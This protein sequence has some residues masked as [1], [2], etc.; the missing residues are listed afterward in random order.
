MIFQIFN[1]KNLSKRGAISSSPFR[2]ATVFQTSLSKT[3]YLSII[4][5]NLKCQLKKLYTTVLQSVACANKLITY[6]L[7]LSKQ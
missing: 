5:G 3:Y 6:L 4:V 1:F 7:Q 2:S